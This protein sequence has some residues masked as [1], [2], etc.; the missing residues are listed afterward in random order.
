MSYCTAGGCVSEAV[1]SLE[2]GTA[3]QRRIVLEALPTAVTEDFRES[4]CYN[5]IIVS[6]LYSTLCMVKSVLVS[7]ISVFSSKPL[8]NSSQQR[9]L[10]GDR[11]PC[12]CDLT[13][14]CDPL[15]SAVR[16][17]K[18]QLGPVSSCSVLSNDQSIASQNVQRLMRSINTPNDRQLWR[19]QPDWKD[20]VKDFADFVAEPLATLVST[21]SIRL[22]GYDRSTAL[23]ML[24]GP[25]RLLQQI[26]SV[27]IE[28]E[29]LLNGERMSCTRGVHYLLGYVLHHPAASVQADAGD[30]MRKKVS[31][32]FLCR[33]PDCSLRR[34]RRSTSGWV[35]RNSR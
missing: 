20:H 16:I 24:L 27:D 30:Q 28:D 14:L 4:E 25:V 13:H 31:H 12:L 32:L 33:R 19:Q 17:A 8:A 11:Q 6:R 29:T 7:Q 18:A 2:V 9:H 22:T 10:Q 3:E 1:D 21:P 5:R 15:S 26:N 34:S 23:L 35:I